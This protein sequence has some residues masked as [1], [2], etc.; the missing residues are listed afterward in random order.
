EQV[1]DDDGNGLNDALI[2]R[3][4]VNVTTAGSYRLSGRLVDGTA[5]PVAAISTT[6]TL[7]AGAQTVDLRFDGGAISASGK[8]G[9]YRL[10][11]IERSGKSG[12][13]TLTEVAV[14]SH[15]DS[16]ISGALVDAYTTAAYTLS[17]F[18]GPEADATATVGGSAV[19][20]NLSSSTQNARFS[21]AG[22]AQK[23]V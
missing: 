9:P 17:Q 11:D 18:A 10:V 5:Y 13:Y 14:A 21:F 15:A 20:L 7:A 4:T 3:P 23:R 2:L 19:S 8:N 12:P 1:V 16:R 22:T 6:A